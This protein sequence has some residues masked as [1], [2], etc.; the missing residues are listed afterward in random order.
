MDS[1][2]EEE[3]DNSLIEH[4]YLR[5]NINNPTSNSDP[6]LVVKYVDD[7]LGSEKVSLEAAKRHFTTEKSVCSVYA[8]KSEH[9][10]D[11]ITENAAVLGLKVNGSKTQ[12]TC[13]NGNTNL[14]VNTFIMDRATNTRV[15]SNE[16]MKILGFYFDSKPSVQKHIE[17]VGRKFR[18]RLWFIR[19]LCKAIKTK[20]KLWTAILVLSVR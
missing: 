12:M 13:I 14:T 17:E 9:L 1:S 7:I 3:L 4:R 2:D 19:H 8:T 5:E 10:I 20:K 18:K 15:S 6:P 11:S 16:S